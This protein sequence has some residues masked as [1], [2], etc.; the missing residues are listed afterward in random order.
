MPL[1]GTLV[2]LL[3]VGGGGCGNT[4]IFNRVLVPLLEAFY[5]SHGVLKEASSNKAARL[6][7][8]KTIHTANKLNGG[9]SLRTVH[10]RLNERRAK[11]LGNIYSKIGGK[12][13]DEHSQINAKLFHA[14]AYI[15]SLARAPIYKL[16][17]ERYAQPLETWGC[18]PVVCVAGDELQLP[19]VPHEASLLAP[20]EGCSD[21]HKA[22][23]AIFAGLKHVYRLTTA[24]RFDDPV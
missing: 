19:P 1:V 20:L 10:L 5:G 15:T 16:A 3:L 17:P 23:V 7:H 22:G 6:L 11:V 21:E 12:I 9:S 8:G 14:D 18:L 2:R 13:I 4:R 24:M